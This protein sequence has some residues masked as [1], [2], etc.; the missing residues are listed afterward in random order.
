LKRQRFAQ[1]RELEKERLEAEI[2]LKSDNE[3]F[4]RIMGGVE[5]ILR[6]GDALVKKGVLRVWRVFF[7]ESS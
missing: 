6:V 1:D 7:A 3:R 5:D 4:D 2:A